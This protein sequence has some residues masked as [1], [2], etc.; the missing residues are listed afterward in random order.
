MSA[1]ATELPTILEQGELRPYAE[2]YEERFGKSPSRVSAWRHC[3]VG[4]RNGALKLD[5][6]FCDGKWWTTAAA[7][8]LFLNRQ[9]EAAQNASRSQ[10]DDAE[11]KKAGL[12]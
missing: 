5:A 3:K 10:D 2:V 6:I 4:L 7:F 1:L 8:N 12:L 9:T 11:L